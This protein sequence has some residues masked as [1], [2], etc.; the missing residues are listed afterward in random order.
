MH[1]YTFL[2]HHPHL[3][4]FRSQQQLGDLYRKT[5][6]GPPHNELLIQIYVNRQITQ[7]LVQFFVEGNP[8]KMPYAWDHV[9]FL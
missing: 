1:L 6:S 7:V 3:N 4:I 5:K 8:S 2:P 9:H